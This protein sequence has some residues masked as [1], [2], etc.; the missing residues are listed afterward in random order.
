[1]RSGRAWGFIQIGTGV[2]QF[3]WTAKAGQVEL[4]LPLHQQ[5]ADFGK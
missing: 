5:V 1:L 2:T 4:H 3:D